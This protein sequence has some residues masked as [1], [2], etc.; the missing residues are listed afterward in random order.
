MTR[1]SGGLGLYICGE[2]GA[3]EKNCRSSITP[4]DCR[5]AIPLVRQTLYSPLGEVL[6]GGD[7]AA[8]ADEQ[9]VQRGGRKEKRYAI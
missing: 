5:Y 1:G 8:L 4:P 7:L 2:L 6:D 3:F 9:A